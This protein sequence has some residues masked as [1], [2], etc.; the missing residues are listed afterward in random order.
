MITYNNI[1][2]ALNNFAT[3]HFF[4]KT[5]THGNV[6]EMDLRKYENYPLMHV[7]YIGANYDVGIKTYSFQVYIMDLP[8]DKLDK[9]SYQREVISDSEQCA[10]DL[11][12]DIVNGGNIFNFD[13]QYELTSASLTPLEEETKNVLAGVVLDLAITIPYQYDSCNAPLEGVTPISG[14]PCPPGIVRNSSLTY[15]VEISSGGTFTLPDLTVIQVNGST[16]SSPAQEGVT[17]QWTQLSVINSE[18]TILEEVTTYPAG[19]RIVVDDIEVEDVDQTTRMVPVG[20]VICEWKDI[21]V[22]DQ[23]DNTL[24]TATTYPSG[25]EI[26]VTIPVVATS[27]AIITHRKPGYSSISTGDYADLYNSGY[28]DIYN[29][30]GPIEMAKI[31]ADNFTLASNNVFGNTSRYTSTD[32]TPSDTGTA[33]FSS[34][35]TGVSGVVIDHLFYIMW[36]NV[37][38]GS[39]STNWNNS[40]ALVDSLNS[41][42]FAGRTNWI[43]PTRDMLSLSATPDNNQAIHT[44]P[45]LIVDTGTRR[46]LTC[47]RIPYLSQGYMVY[48]SNAGE[49]SQSLTTTASGQNRVVAGCILTLAELEAL[50]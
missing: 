14:G 3:N 47:E 43:V 39:S 36:Y 31:G 13:Y 16:T 1:I 42:S 17:C 48:F 12:A 10:E 35:G 38:Q 6:E 33:R 32:G 41:S 9:I 27:P 25:G 23:D 24:A 50:V 40:Q 19:N 21:T 29:P 37:P 18:E 45:N 34:Y 8:S 4:I 26:Q 2:T 11:L 49:T 46:Y 22:K 44:S 15:E 30:S 28:F 20:P 7:D 5:F